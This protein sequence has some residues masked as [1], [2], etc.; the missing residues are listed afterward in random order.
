MTTD[1]DQAIE[2]YHRAIEQFVTAGDPE[3]VLRLFSERDG[4]SL[5]NPLGPPARGK[6]EIH[7][8][9][10]RAGSMLRDGEDMRW[11]RISEAATPDLAYIFEIERVR[12]KIAGS[13][14]LS[15][16]A[17][18]TTTVFRREDGS[19]KI[20]H[21]HA[22]PIMG[23]RPPESI[24]ER[25]A[26]PPAGVAPRS[27][28]IRTSSVPERC[29]AIERI[30]VKDAGWDEPSPVELRTTT[31]CPSASSQMGPAVRP[32][33][34]RRDRRDELPVDRCPLPKIAPGAT[35]TTLLPVGWRVGPTP[36]DAAG[37]C[38]EVYRSTPNYA[39]RD[40]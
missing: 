15:P 16:V 2:E 31:A 25:S 33:R 18:R 3:P 40:R 9:A 27:R 10:Q 29:V 21:R 5:A 30:R 19:W 17:L 23:P 1:L 39:D 13:G 38:W 12:V 32:C 8:A 22:D 28:A 26:T 7:M 11:E 34:D 36:H 14:E 35:F 24:I 20:D 6:A 4:A 37:Y